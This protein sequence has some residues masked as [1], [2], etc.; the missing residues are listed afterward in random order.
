ME[1]NKILVSDG[2]HFSINRFLSSF[3]FQPGQKVVIKPN[4]VNS[5][6]PSMGVTTSMKMME[7]VIKFLKK[8]QVHI[9]IAEGSGY[10][11]NT[12][13]A[14]EVLGVDRF[15]SKYGVKIVNTRDT[16]NTKKV[17]LHGKLL[18]RINLPSE[19]VDADWIINIPKL[20]THVLTGMSLCMK[21]LFGL[22]PDKERRFAHVFGLGQ[23]IVD[24]T[25]YFN[26]RTI[27]ILDG[28]TAMSGEGPVFGDTFNLNLIFA[29]KNMADIDRLCCKMLA[30]DFRKIHHI[31]M[32]KNL[33]SQKVT[34]IPQFKP[35][36]VR[37]ALP[38]ASS[39]YKFRYWGVFAF[40]FLQSRF[41]GKSYI[42]NIVTR[43][44]VRLNIDNSKCN[45]CGKCLQLCPVGAITQTKSGFH[46]DFEK[47]RYVRCFKCFDTCEKDAITIKGFSRPHN[48]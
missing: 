30:V 43:F 16:K 42:P 10:E 40:D 19:V 21:N 12:K 24:L 33:F 1:E 44:G 46:I 45:R 28:L 17:N 6:D 27:N 48:K 26:D 32:A 39:Y 4:W 11:F 23:A 15:T 34:I 5:R 31:R 20:K 13:K 9:A 47:C 37:F 29:G 2:A 18:K 41:T 3:P 8:K 25:G 14:F 38:T 7:E 35:K 36:K 22:L